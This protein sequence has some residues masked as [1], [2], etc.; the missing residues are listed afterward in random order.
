MRFFSCVEC[1]DSLV[2]YK[3]LVL[4][5]LCD[6]GP[7]SLVEIHFFLS[8]SALVFEKHMAR[9]FDSKISAKFG[10]R[11][12]IR[13]PVRPDERFWSCGRMVGY[14]TLRIESELE[15]E[16]RQQVREAKRSLLEQK[17]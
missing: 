14:M 9:F 10:S 1:H 8:S 11:L 3:G 2:Q 4:Q 6:C 13:V 16:G 15:K 17:R 5:R 7:K 12:S